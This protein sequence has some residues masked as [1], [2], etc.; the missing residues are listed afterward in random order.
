MEELKTLLAAQAESPNFIVIII[1]FLFC[2]S[3]TYFVRLAYLRFSGAMSSSK[4]IANVLVILACVTYLVILVVKSS[5]ALSL[6]LVGAL[7]IVRFRT[8]VKEPEE[9]V[10]LFM[11]I[12]VG[13]GTGAGQTKATAI[14]IFLTLFIYYLFARRRSLSQDRSLG[15]WLVR[16]QFS[17]SGKIDEVISRSD[18]MTQSRQ[19]SR[20]SVEDEHREL[21]MYVVIKH[22]VL[23]GDFTKN[24]EEIAGVTSV[25]IQEQNYQL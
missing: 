22:D 19:I 20:L 21:T 13:L 5:L 4:Q 9:L 15:D 16:V 12:G 11:A 1:N 18:G 3:I 2:A 8:P 14:V 25:S 17:P 24:L 10:F 23:I 7:S 6:G